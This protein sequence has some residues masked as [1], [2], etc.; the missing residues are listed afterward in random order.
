M[1]ILVILF[2]LCLIYCAG[3]AGRRASERLRARLEAETQRKTETEEN[4][5]RAFKI[6]FDPDANIFSPKG[7]PAT[8][9]YYGE[10][11]KMDF[12][13]IIEDAIKFFNSSEK[14]IN[15][16]LYAL[17]DQHHHIARLY[18]ELTY[19]I[20]VMGLSDTSFLKENLQQVFDAY[21]HNCEDA[22]ACI[23]QC[24]LG[25]E[26]NYELA[27]LDDIATDNEKLLVTLTECCDS[28][29]EYSSRITY[30]DTPV[31][32]TDFTGVHE[33]E[34]FTKKIR[35]IT[36]TTESEF[37][38]AVKEAEKEDLRP[39]VPVIEV[40]KN[41]RVSATSEH[42]IQ[43]NNEHTVKPNYEHMVKPNAKHRVPRSKRHEVAT[44]ETTETVYDPM[45]STMPQSDGF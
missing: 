40:P 6:D 13:S 22:I 24:T 28:V 36:E 12:I 7:T 34:K 3:V 5:S 41:C 37:D 31:H 17:R 35:N 30:D 29:R 39:D 38:R 4:E 45:V 42:L 23:R 32:L 11:V 8:E 2:S 26:T 1:E 43:Q 19:V 9:D 15:T 21:T 44:E 14:G 10:Q 27:V 25:G 20:N 18:E 33:L 16:K